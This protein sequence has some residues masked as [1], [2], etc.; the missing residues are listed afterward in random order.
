MIQMGK[1]VMLVDGMALLFR[2]FYAT[3]YRNNY[4]RTK[5]GTPT[6]G[7]FQ[8]LQYL[9]DAVQ[10]FDPTHVICCWDVGRKTFR[11]EIYEDYKA[12]REDPLKELV[13]QFGLIKD[14]MDIL[15][16]PNISLENYEA[17]DCIGTL[18]KSL[19]STAHILILTGDLDLLQLVS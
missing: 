1:K 15:E 13:P 14:V 10:T 12:N 19:Q 7:I 17:D 3:A 18:A 16:V 8:F 11:T 9:F 4:M 2:G 6:N 5:D